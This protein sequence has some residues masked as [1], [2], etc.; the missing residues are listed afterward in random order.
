MFCGISSIADIQAALKRLGKFTSLIE[1]EIAS[2]Y[3]LYRTFTGIYE[4][5][6]L[7]TLC[8]ALLAEK[9]EEAKVRM[10]ID[11]FGKL[12]WNSTVDSDVEYVMRAYQSGIK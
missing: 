9:G 10:F 2:S 12:A 6:S 1:R 3:G 8:L 11:R 5:R 4:A 7:F